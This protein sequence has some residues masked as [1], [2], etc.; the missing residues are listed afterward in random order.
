MSGQSSLLPAEH[1][2]EIRAEIAFVAHW[3]KDLLGCAFVVEA[4]RQYAKSVA[5]SPKPESNSDYEIDPLDWHNLATDV[6]KEFKTIFEA[7]S[8]E[9]TVEVQEGFVK[10][11]QGDSN[12]R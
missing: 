5:E 12:V 4:I 9:K 11:L 8:E 2:P 1:M 10:P 6:L 7:T 3:M